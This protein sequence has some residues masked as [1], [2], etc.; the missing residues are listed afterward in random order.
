MV[1]KENDMTRNPLG[2]IIIAS[3]RSGGTLLTHSLDSHPLISCMRG[4]PFHARSEWCVIPAK[5]RIELLTNFTGVLASGFKIQN[6]Q[7]TYP[8]MLEF[9][10]NL[11]LKIIRVTRENILAQAI[12]LVIN[13]QTRVGNLNIPQHT[14]TQEALVPFELPAIPVLDACITLEKSNADILNLL[15]K[16]ELETLDITYEQLTENAITIQSIPYELTGKLCKYLKVGRFELRNFL[17][18]INWK[19]YP[20]I[21]INWNEIQE[22]ISDTPYKRFL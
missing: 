15:N 6:N 12:S 13:N 17:H 7:L 14:F 20:E 1:L 16:S 22:Q 2:F 18:R 10:K 11:N 21:I 19:P 9:I 3:V 8:N 4:E 5:Y